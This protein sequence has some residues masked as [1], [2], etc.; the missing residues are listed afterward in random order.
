MEDITSM[1][2]E[3][4]KEIYQEELFNRWTYVDKYGESKEWIESR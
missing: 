1:I 2:E 4:I 3:K